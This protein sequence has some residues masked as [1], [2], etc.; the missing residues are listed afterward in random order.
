MF[1]SEILTDDSGGDLG[2]KKNP[3]ISLQTLILTL[4]LHSMEKNAKTIKKK[5]LVYYKNTIL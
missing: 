5:G 3:K 2:L 1:W 4:I